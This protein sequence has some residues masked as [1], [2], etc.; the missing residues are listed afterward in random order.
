M[1]MK[2]IEIKRNSNIEDIDSL[3]YDF[4]DKIDE[5]EEYKIVLPKKIDNLFF[6]LN[7]N[8]LQ[9]VSTIFKT[10]RLNT[11]QVRIDSNNKI[12]IQNIYDNE[13]FFP[14]ISLLWNEVNIIDINE[15]NL[16]PILREYQNDFFKNMRASK[17]MKGEKFLLA[18]LDH[19]SEDK[20]ILKLFETNGEFNSNEYSFKKSLE[21]I[22][23]DDVLKYSSNNQLQFEKIKDDI[24]SIIYE[25]MKNTFEWAKHDISGKIINPNIRGVYFKFHKYGIDNILHDY[26]NTLPIYQY[27]SG[28]SLNINTKK[29]VYFIEISVFDTGLGFIDRYNGNGSDIDIIKK[30]LI[31]NQTSS[32][33][34]LKD[35]KGLGLDRILSILNDKGLF[36]INTDRYSLFRNL[37]IDRYNSEIGLGDLSSIV[38]RDWKDLSDEDIKP[39]KFK[40]SGTT[41]SILYPFS[42]SNL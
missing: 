6:S 15:Y 5:S 21:Q 1:K 11:I 19:F 30:C 29:E 33:S 27:F 2:T 17:S 22:I 25:L 42:Q 35:K 36:K 31:K 16:R 28:S 13:F 10:G 40:F 41:I 7:V 39:K 8:L 12:E 38:L 34:N 9:F 23:K 32:V 24:S 18:N 14:I 26:K 37:K 4:F 3:Y 20:G